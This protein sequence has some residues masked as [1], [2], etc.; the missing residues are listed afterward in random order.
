MPEADQAAAPAL[1]SFVRETVCKWRHRDHHEV[2]NA[3]IRSTK[4]G[5]LSMKHPSDQPTCSRRLARAAL[6]LPA[7]AL[8]SLPSA[9][10]AAGL[11]DNL[12]QLECKSIASRNV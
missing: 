3:P 12:T 5:R 10:F 9:L 11:C 1:R 4:E 2:V 6:L 7:V 8:C